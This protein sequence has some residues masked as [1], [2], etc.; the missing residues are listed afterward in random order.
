MHEE[1]KHSDYWRG[2]YRHVAFEIVRWQDYENKPKWNY[3]ID[4]HEKQIPP[5]RLAEFDMPK[6]GDKSWDRYEYYQSDFAKLDWHGDCTFYQKK[7]GLDG[8]PKVFR[9]GCDYSHLFDQDMEYSEACLVADCHRTIDSLWDL[10]PDLKIWCSQDGS[11]CSLDEGGYAEH[12]NFVSHAA[13]K[14]MAEKYPDRKQPVIVS[15]AV[16]GLLTV[17]TTTT[18]RRKVTMTLSPREETNE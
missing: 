17:K 12:G 13:I 9:A 3:Y 4:V 6:K 16:R 15:P 11:Y 14:A 8:E 18:E 5:D 1:M 10:V 2:V 7:G